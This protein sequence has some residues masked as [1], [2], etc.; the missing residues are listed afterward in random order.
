[1]G[2]TGKLN[3]IPAR[4]R[5]LMCGG[6][7]PSN[8]VIEESDSNSSVMNLSDTVFEFLDE[9][10]SP[11][12][13]PASNGYREIEDTEENN[14]D[15]ED[16]KAF[17][18]KQHQILRS[19]LYRTTSLESRIRSTTH[20]SLKELQVT[21]NYC[22]CGRSGTGG[23]RNCLMREVSSRLRLAGFNCVVSKS[24]W[25]SSNEIPAGEHTYLGVIEEGKVIVIELNFRGEF[26]M[27]KGSEEYKELINKLPE[28]FVGK[29]KRLQSLIKML[30]LAAKKCMKDKKMHLGPWRRQKYM[31]AKW[32]AATATEM[33]DPATVSRWSEWT[34]RVARS[35]MLTVDL[36]EMLPRMQ[37]A[38]FAL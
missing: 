11:V 9:N 24:K 34:G 29:I 10:V 35:S 1:M 31:E 18:D 21:G 13:T 8:C 25:K 2:M 27:A 26:E 4:N 33:L 23:C 28:V 17:W 3:K 6:E 7:Y 38:V 15:E 14:G 36:V 19:T 30:C 12:P 16:D 32:L 37:Y 22:C 20:E 5:I